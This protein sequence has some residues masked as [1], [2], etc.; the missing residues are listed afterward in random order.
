MNRLL[1]LGSTLGIL[2]LL[3]SAPGK[4]QDKKGLGGKKPALTAN[5]YPLDV[6]N[7]WTYK[8]KVGEKSAILV[9]TI[10]KVETVNGLSLALLEGELN[11]ER[12]TTEHLR[13]TEAGVF[14]Y[15][16]NGADLDPPACLVQYPVKSGAKWQ[17]Q[18]KI[19]AEPVMYFCEAKEESVVV[20]AGKFKA[21][22]IAMHLESKDRKS[23]TTYWFV[24]D[25]GIVKQTVKQTVEDGGLSAMMELEKFERVK[26]APKKDKSP[27]S[28]TK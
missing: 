25:L 20:P 22:R 15:R 3:A 11:G 26:P 21:I 7:Q 14:R 17:G 18:F 8:V 2:I 23:T 19:S 1:R 4:A 24:K 12:K 9:S 6:G 13:Q 16:N 5:Y 10:T 28:S 27:N